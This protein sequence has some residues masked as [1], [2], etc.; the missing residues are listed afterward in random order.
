MVTIASQLAEPFNDAV[1]ALLPDVRVIGIPRGV[2]A[3]LPEQTSILIAGLRSYQRP[4]TVTHA[5]FL[6]VVRLLKYFDPSP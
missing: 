4:R 6:S 3:D 2:P 5:P 1:R